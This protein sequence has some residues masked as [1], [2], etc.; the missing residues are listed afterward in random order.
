M[1]SK[2]YITN[3]FKQIYSE[4]L[5]TIQEIQHESQT[6]LKTVKKPLNNQSNFVLVSPELI[7]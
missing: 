2:Y 3:L 1:L 5:K 6:T 4:I 7:D